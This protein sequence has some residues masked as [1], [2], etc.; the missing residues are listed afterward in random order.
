MLELIGIEKRLSEQS[1]SST[2]T[3]TNS[4]WDLMTM[5]TYVKQRAPALGQS[6]SL[7]SGK[8][9]LPIPQLTDMLN[10]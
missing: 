9:S 1:T 6:N 5:K 3:K 7:K 8:R 2:G 4:K 10:I